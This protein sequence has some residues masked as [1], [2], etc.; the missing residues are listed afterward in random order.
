[1][2]FD[3]LVV[4]INFLTKSYTG[5]APCIISVRNYHRQLIMYIESCSVEL[6]FYGEF[7]PGSG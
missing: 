2:N 4:Q 6:H 7:D 3:N 1:M 5:F